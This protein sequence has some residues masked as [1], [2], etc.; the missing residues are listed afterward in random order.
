MIKKE[1][2]V[3]RRRRIFFGHRTLHGVSLNKSLK[4]WL[5]THPGSSF[6]TQGW[7][8]SRVI[9][10]LQVFHQF[11]N[12]YVK[13]YPWKWFDPF[14]R[15]NPDFRGL[16]FYYE[17][18]KRKLKPIKPA[19]ECRC[20]GRLQTKRFTRFTHTGLVGLDDSSQKI[21]GLERIDV[22]SFIRVSR[23][24]LTLSLLDRR[25]FFLPRLHAFSKSKT[26]KMT[27]ILSRGPKW[28]AA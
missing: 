7:R 23:F 17:S 12:G 8:I 2:S 27:H 1:K 3:F 6:H 22:I 14:C 5:T 28:H 13:L 20:N 4:K 10:K 18:M 11:L 16:F 19:Y 15:M 21:L 25:S 26:S 9:Y 24:D